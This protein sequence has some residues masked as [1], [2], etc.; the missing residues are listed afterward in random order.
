MNI[1]EI[2]EAKKKG[3]ELSNGQIEFVVNGFTA[4]DFAEYQVS[5]TNRTRRS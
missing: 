3:L 5:G 4:G 2:L 1:L